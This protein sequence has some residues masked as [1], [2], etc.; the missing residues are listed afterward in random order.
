MEENKAN[1]LDQFCTN[2][3][4]RA[5][6]GKIDP[7]I[8]RE[9]T[10]ERITQVLMRRTKNNPLLIGEPGV[11]K[12]A[13]I[14]GLAKKIIEG[15]VP[16]VL[17]NKLIYSLDMGSLLAGT[18]FRGDFENRIKTVLKEVKKNPN[19]V[20]FIDEI[21]TLVGAGATSGGSM[22]ASNLLKPALA[23]GEVS[24]IGSTT[25]T[26]FRQHFEKDRALN[27]RFQKIDIQEP[28]IADAIEILKG[29]AT[30]FEKY[31]GVKYSQAALKSAVE[32]SVKHI[33]N[34]LLPDKAIDVIDECGSYF[35]LK[36]PNTESILIEPEQIEE[37][38]A[39]ITG[40]PV[41]Q[42]SSNEKAQLKDLDKKLKALIFGQD[43][44]IDKLVASIKLSL[45]EGN[46][47]L[48]LP[49]LLF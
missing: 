36:N 15:Q 5:R 3:N 10:L 46:D 23:N 44:A 40:L 32:L 45:E 22:D 27:R 7:L 29:I 35:R 6:A 21:H 30:Q 43:E 47:D 26:E 16:E 49:H 1:A 31:H 14:E 42:V 34:K 48:S 24:C 41:A 18:K 28:S 11:G 9:D 13:V 4:E 37:V 8:G 25:H 19:I 39:K 12:T 33:N 17:K 2:L 20:L 38:I